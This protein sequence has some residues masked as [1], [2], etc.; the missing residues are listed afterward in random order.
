MKNTAFIVFGVFLALFLS[1]KGIVSCGIQKQFLDLSPATSSLDANGNNLEDEPTFP[2][3]HAGLYAMGKD[4]YEE[5]GCV[6]CHTQ[7]VR[8]GDV[9]LGLGK[10]QSVARD[11]V[12]Q[13]NMQLGSLRIG[14]DLTN[15]GL[16]EFK[17]EGKKASFEDWMYLM[18][19]NPRI[20]DSQN[21]MPSYSFLF[22]V[23]MRMAQKSSN[24]L[25]F[26][27][28]STFSPDEGYEVVPSRRAEALVYYLKN[29][30]QDYELPEMKFTG[31]SK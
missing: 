24:T 12:F 10:R 25:V 21:F 20:L 30:K 5:L 4:V 28:N 2:E 29:L 13:K 22:N 19:R 31:E 1:W 11:Y 15:L 3:V 7:Q 17:V 23:K 14:P 27:E 18:L 16:R 26:P 9:A 6:S 8:S